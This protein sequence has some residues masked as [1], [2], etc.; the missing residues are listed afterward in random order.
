[1]SAEFPGIC[2]IRRSWQH[3]GVNCTLSVHADDNVAF[4]DIPV[5]GVCLPAWRDFSCITLSWFFSLRA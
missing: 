2:I 3:A 1:M 5:F 4:E